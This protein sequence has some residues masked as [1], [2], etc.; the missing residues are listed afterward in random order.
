MALM[1]I[2]RDVPVCSRVMVDTFASLHPRR[3]KLMNID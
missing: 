2:H 3:I 1:H